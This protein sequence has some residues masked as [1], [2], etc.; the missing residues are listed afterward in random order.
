[1][2]AN[3]YKTTKKNMKSEWV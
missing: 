1:M 2:K 3:H